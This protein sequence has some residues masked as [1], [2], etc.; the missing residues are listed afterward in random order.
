MRNIIAAL[1]AGSFA[2]GAYA[3]ATQPQSLTR[4]GG[5]TSPAAQAAGEAK[6][7][8]RMTK[9]AKDKS[10]KMERS[11]TTPRGDAASTTS[12]AK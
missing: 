3:Q 2:F 12:T 11:S 4:E 7:D 6:K 5:S 10:M 8:A 9:P 1:L